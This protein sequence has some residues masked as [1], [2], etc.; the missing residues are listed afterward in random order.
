[1]ATSSQITNYI[2]DSADPKKAKFDI[3]AATRY[4]VAQKAASDDYTETT[5]SFFQGRAVLPGP[6]AN[7]V[8]GT[9]PN[10]NDL[11]VMENQYYIRFIDSATTDNADDSVG[12][13]LFTVM[14]ASEADEYEEVLREESNKRSTIKV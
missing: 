9:I 13:A 7:K 6:R 1:M 5:H 4:L 2:L 10:V 8:F 3:W 14:T 11:N 12:D